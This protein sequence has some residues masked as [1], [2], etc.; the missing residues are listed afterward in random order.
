MVIPPGSHGQT[1]RPCFPGNSKPRAK[2]PDVVRQLPGG[3]GQV[4]TGEADM[5]QVLGAQAS[6]RIQP[7]PP[8][9]PAQGKE[10][11][12]YGGEMLARGSVRCKTFRQQRQQRQQQQ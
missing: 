2:V 11:R 3:Q 7:F 9:G 1:K 8:H 6:V 10:K 5:P 4:R 12:H